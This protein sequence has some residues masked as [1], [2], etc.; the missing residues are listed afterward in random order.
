V[1][2]LGAPVGIYHRMRAKRDGA[3]VTGAEEPRLI[4]I[5][6]KLCGLLAMLLMLTWLIRPR[7][8]DWAAA[9][10]PNGLRWTGV[11]ITVLAFSLVG[12][13]FHTLGH[14]L[15]DTVA[16]RANSYLVTGGPYRVVRHPFY[17]AI[18]LIGTGLTL[19]TALWPAG[20]LMAAVL[21]L[22]AIRTPIE[23]RKLIE[24]FGDG[25]RDYA[26]RTARYV[27]GLW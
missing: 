26:A 24:R 18:F 19:A 17:V 13:T 15:T 23:E 20:I 5:P 27:P 4:R 16:T 3:K 11:G 12:W 25:Y 2:L 7:L 1:I 10:L 6:L 21:T 8:I 14:N 9:P 22:L